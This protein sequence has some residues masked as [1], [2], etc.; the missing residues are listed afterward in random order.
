LYYLTKE[1]DNV[2]ETDAFKQ[3]PADIHNQISKLRKPSSS[4]NSDKKKEGCLLQ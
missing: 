4:K 1:F 2:S 3:L